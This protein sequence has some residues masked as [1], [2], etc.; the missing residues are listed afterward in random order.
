MVAPAGLHRE[1][2]HGVEHGQDV[3]CGGHGGDAL[4]ASVLDAVVDHAGLG[5]ENRT[6]DRGERRGTD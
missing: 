2:C 1:H 4:V 3:D 5:E 6:E